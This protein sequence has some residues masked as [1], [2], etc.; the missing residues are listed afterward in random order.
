MTNR[1]FRRKF[2]CTLLS[3]WHHDSRLGPGKNTIALFQDSFFSQKNFYTNESWKR[4]PKTQI[5]Y[6]FNLLSLRKLHHYLN[7]T[8]FIV[9]YVWQ[10][11][12]TGNM[13]MLICYQ[14]IH[15]E[16][17][18]KIWNSRESIYVMKRII[19]TCYY[20]FENRLGG[21]KKKKGRERYILFLVVITS[22]W[23]CWV[24]NNLLGGKKRT[25]C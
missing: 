6:P 25:E 2:L 22:V 15:L 8:S 10:W 13:L 4:S 17:H 3:N 20:L 9:F 14:G 1:S 7:L 24:C 16:N 5:K 19:V 23:R 18:F 11:F 21:K 12:H